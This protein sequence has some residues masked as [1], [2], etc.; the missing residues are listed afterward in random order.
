MVI[1][2]EK[3]ESGFEYSERQ[4]ILA[5]LKLFRER[6][7]EANALD[8]AKYF[9]EFFRLEGSRIVPQPL[10]SDDIDVL[11]QAIQDGYPSPRR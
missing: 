5:A 2:M 7:D 9:P 3:V 1:E 6:F 10:G 8:I 11:I 4:T